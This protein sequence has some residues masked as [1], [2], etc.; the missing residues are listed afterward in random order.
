MEYIDFVK[1]DMMAQ[2]RLANEIMSTEPFIRQLYDDICATLGCYKP[3]LIVDA[4]GNMQYIESMGGRWAQ[5]GIYYPPGMIHIALIV[6]LLVL[7]WMSLIEQRLLILLLM[8]S[9]ILCK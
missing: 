7:L 9:L 5:P 3:I 6:R 8:S 1:Q 2:C 4:Y